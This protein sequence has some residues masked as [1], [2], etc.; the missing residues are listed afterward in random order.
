MEF[1]FTLGI[2]CYAIIV[3]KKKKKT[4][5]GECMFTKHDKT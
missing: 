4:E 5:Y 2:T 3:Q 1:C